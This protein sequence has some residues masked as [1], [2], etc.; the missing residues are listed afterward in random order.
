VVLREIASPSLLCW[1]LLTLALLGSVGQAQTTS[2][3][4]IVPWY[5][6]VFESQTDL[7]LFPSGHLTPGTGTAKLTEIDSQGR[8]RFNQEDRAPAMGYGLHVVA[9]GSEQQAVP[10][11][12]TDISGAGAMTLGSVS[13]WEIDAEAGAGYAGN[14]VFSDG[15]AWY[16]RGT[17]LATHSF[18]ADRE[19]QFLVEYDGNRSTFP[20]APLPGVEYRDKVNDQ[21]S[22]ILGYP[23]TSITFKPIEPLE[24]TVNWYIPQSFDANLEYTITQHW[25]VVGT[26]AA[27]D[28]P[29]HSTTLPSD[30]RLFFLQNRFEAAVRWTLSDSFNLLVAAGYAFDRRINSGWDERKLTPVA[31]LSD[32]PYL[33]LTATISF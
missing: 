1:F 13:G 9:L 24:C 4:L 23:T 17:I 16:G 30:R 25:S 27:T 6:D 19:L 15:A 29:F 33:R 22:F 20:D 28:L 18:S 5:G 10:P 26:F 32:Q 8:W 31:S 7:F 3:M 11:I 12:L 21:L 2:E 14:H